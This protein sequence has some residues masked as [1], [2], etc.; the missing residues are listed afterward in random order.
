MAGY[1]APYGYGSGYGYG[2]EIHI[3]QISAASQSITA[4]DDTITADSRI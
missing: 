4:D 1:G 3:W 2:I